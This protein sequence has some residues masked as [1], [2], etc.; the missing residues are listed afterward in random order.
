MFAKII[1]F[2]FIDKK[3]SH[4]T[5][6]LVAVIVAALKLNNYIISEVFSSFFL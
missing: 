3:Y 4:C 6:E 1:L 5:G 2:K